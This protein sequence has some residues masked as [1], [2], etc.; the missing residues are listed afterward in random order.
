MASRASAIFV[1][2]SSS[3]LRMSVSRTI[4]RAGHLVP[5]ILLDLRIPRFGVQLEDAVQVLEGVPKVDDCL[6]IPSGGFE[7]LNRLR[8]QRAVFDGAGQSRSSE[9]SAE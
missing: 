3:T 5:Q 7:L 1:S 9:G 4:G 8:C 2:M 6:L